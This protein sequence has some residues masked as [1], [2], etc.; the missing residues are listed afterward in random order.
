MNR[1]ASRYSFLLGFLFLASSLGAKNFIFDLGGVLIDT[2]GMAAFQELG[3]VNVAKL[4]FQQQLN[5]LTINAHIKTKLFEILDCVAAMHV[6]ENELCRF[7]ACDEH[8]KLPYLMC[9][10]LNG[11]VT[12]SQACDM[13]TESIAVNPQWFDCYAQQCIIS[14][15][16]RM[17]FTPERFIATRK[18]YGA[19]VAFIK[20]IKA[21]GHKV[22]VLSNWDS[23]SFVLLQQKYPELFGLFDGMVI[24]GDVHELKPSENIYRILLNRYNLRPEDCWFI[25]DQKENIDAAHNCGVNAIMCP[26][27][28]NFCGLQKYPNFKLIAHNI[29]KFYSKSV[30]RRENRKRSGMSV[31]SV[32]NTSSAMMEGE[33]ISLTDSTIYSCLPANA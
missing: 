9:A 5:P 19:G 15:L 12:C 21:K 31:S 4:V 11:T 3:K 26:Y 7:A 1:C 32:K 24:S 25:D 13:T 2:N 23:E 28:N 18:M 27:I 22:F 33:K 16:C 14:N 6:P 30:T 17:I 29:Q 8:G 10:W 20:A